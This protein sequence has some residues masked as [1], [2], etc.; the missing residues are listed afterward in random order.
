VIKAIV[1]EDHPIFREG[2][3]K[4]VSQSG[5]ITIADE[6]SDGTTL[7]ERAKAHRYD[8]AILDISLPGASGLD[9]LKDLRR[10]GHQMPVLILSM[11]PEE[12]YALRA[13]RAGASGYV[14]KASVPEELITAIRKVAAGRR[15]V[16]P[17]LAEQLAAELDG[18]A[19]KPPHERLSDREFQ[20]MR[21]ISSGKRMKEIA[22]DL[23]LSPATVGTYRARI[24]SK[25]NLQSNAE[26]IHYT[27]ENK[28]LE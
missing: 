3:K 9:L 14:A 4:I 19:D 13:L 6:V 7:M 17:G 8:V 25:L 15:Y 23:N 2:L 20:I 27:I 28:L 21:M 22:G 1:C 5:D 18:L 12:Q 24:L 26:L 16:S 11:H 10:A